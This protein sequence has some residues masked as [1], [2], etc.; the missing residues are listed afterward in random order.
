MVLA[1]LS[2]F[3]PSGFPFVWAF[4][5]SSLVNA[6]Y[7]FVLRM[8]EDTGWG[9]REVEDDWARFQDAYELYRQQNPDR[10]PQKM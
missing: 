5:K 8:N 7:L 9:L 6:K 4:L 2:D 1:V 10:L 3:Y